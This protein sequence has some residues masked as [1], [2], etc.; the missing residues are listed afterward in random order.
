M[1]SEA[2]SG[3][4]ARPSAS[5]PPPGLPGG[6]L[7]LGQVQPKGLCFASLA[8]PAPPPRKPWWL[9]NLLPVEVPD[10]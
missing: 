9:R 2:V 10:S 3:L 1:H 8:A 4:W 5:Q 7:K 6:Q